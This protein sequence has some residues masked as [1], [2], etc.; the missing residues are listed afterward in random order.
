MPQA[1]WPPSLPAN[2]AAAKAGA[3]RIWLLRDGLPVEASV[4]T[5]LDDDSMTELVSGDVK[6]GDLV[7]TA[8]ARAA[9]AAALPPPRL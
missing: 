1:S 2:A 6:L 5:G 7:I 3:S 4:V 9:T 8:E